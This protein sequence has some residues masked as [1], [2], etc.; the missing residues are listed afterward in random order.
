MPGVPGAVA[1][2]TG[3]RPP[4]HPPAAATRPG[5][6]VLDLGWQREDDV[7]ALRAGDPD[8]EPVAAG[9]RGMTE[10]LLRRLLDGLPLSYRL[11]ARARE[12]EIGK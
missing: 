4:N 1:A 2:V 9:R 5:P 6:Q 3:P 11:V 8:M 12:R 10:R 7:A